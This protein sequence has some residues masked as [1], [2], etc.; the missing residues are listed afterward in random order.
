VAIHDDDD[1]WHPRYL[2]SCVD[3]LQKRGPDATCQG[4]ITRITQM[5]E[6]VHDNTIVRLYSR[7][8]MPVEEIGLTT[9]IKEN[10]IAPIAFLFRR[11]V[12]DKLG[13]FNPDFSVLGDW[14]FNL[15]FLS[16]YEIGIIKRYLANYHWRLNPQDSTTGNTVTLGI[17]EHREQLRRLRNYYLQ[18]EAMRQYP[19][20]GLLLYL[21]LDR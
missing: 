1:S 18:A 4:V 13:M 16:Y 17:A 20:I 5:Y 3:F 12:L 21:E 9:I 7:P 2:E 8:Y 10:V 6:E 15:R 14:D 11:K 19:N